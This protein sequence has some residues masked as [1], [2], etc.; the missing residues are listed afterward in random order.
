MLA[1]TLIIIVLLGVL[2]YYIAQKLPVVDA[3]RTIL[4]GVAIIL[5]GGFIVIDPDTELGGL[6]Y[7]ILIFGFILAV[8]GFFKAE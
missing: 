6:P 1:A 4:L 5:L 2:M 7:L 3:V 8:T